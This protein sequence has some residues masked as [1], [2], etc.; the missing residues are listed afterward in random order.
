[1]PTIPRR[2]LLMQD[3]VGG[4]NNRSPVIFQ[5][6][7]IYR[8][9]GGIN[10][11]I[12]SES[13]WSVGE[14][15]LAEAIKVMFQLSGTLDVEKGFSG[16]AARKFGF[17]PEQFLHG[18]SHIIDTSHMTQ[19]CD[20]MSVSRIMAVLGTS[21]ALLAHSAAA[22]CCFMNRCAID[23]YDRKPH[24]HWSCGVRRMASSNREMD[25]PNRSMYASESPRAQ[26]AC[27]R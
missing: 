26:W 3:L 10:G 16:E 25:S 27:A 8:F 14:T 23:R 1:M 2:I 20:K 4:D 17:F 13:L 22:S 24:L 21:I 9:V 11:S 18:G 12:N 5:G 19:G 15:C 6:S 7:D